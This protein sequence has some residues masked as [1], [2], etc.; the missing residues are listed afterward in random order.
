M[1]T[2]PADART[3]INKLTVNGTEVYGTGDTGVYRLDAR[4]QWEQFSTE[5]PN[6]VVSLA[7]VNGRLYSASAEQGI[8]YISLTEQ[9]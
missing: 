3:V 2:D 5:T 4:G 7:V 1:V 8:F 6:S 9:Q